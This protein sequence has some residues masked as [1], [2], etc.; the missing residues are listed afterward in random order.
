MGAG[1]GKANI[2]PKVQQEAIERYAAKLCGEIGRPSSQYRLR[3]EVARLHWHEV[4]PGTRR[5]SAAGLLEPLAQ[6]L[7]DLGVVQQREVVGGADVVAVLG[8]EWDPPSAGPARWR[9]ASARG[10]RRAGAPGDGAGCG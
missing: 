1:K 4:A 3:P 7:V 9:W 8:L 2:A 10:C 6:A 5:G